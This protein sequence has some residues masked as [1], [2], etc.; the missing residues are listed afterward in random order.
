M[1][2]RYSD[3]ESYVTKDGSIIRELMHPQ[4]HGN[5]KQSLAEA[6]VPPG[7]TTMA[8]VHHRT[9]ELYHVVSGRGRMFLGDDAFEV[10][11]GDTVCIA[12]GTRH[13]IVNVGDDDLRVLCCC[14]PA[15][16][17]DDTELVPGADDGVSDK[18]S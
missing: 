18:E 3:I 2:T 15:Y 14:S 8:H 11:P 9:E 13:S 10:R 6:T 5:A 17:H 16:A 4:V 7:A 12:P 1:R